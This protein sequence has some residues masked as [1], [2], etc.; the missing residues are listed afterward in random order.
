MFIGS[1]NARTAGKQIFLHSGLVRSHQQ[2]RVDQDAEHTKR[3]VMFDEADPAHVRCEVIDF[4]YVAG[5]SSLAGRPIL[6]IK[7]HVLYVFKSLIPLFKWLDI[8]R[9]N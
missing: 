6:Q 5:H 2:M 9:E 1:V 8:D 7:C 3:F 4:A